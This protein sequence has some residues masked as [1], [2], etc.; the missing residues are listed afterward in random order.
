MET[1]VASTMT[2]PEQVEHLE[3][4]VSERLDTVNELWKQHETTL[5]SIA[6]GKSAFAVYASHQS[7][8]DEPSTYL[9]LGLQ[10]VNGVWGI[11]YTHYQEEFDPKHDGWTSIH[12]CPAF[13][14]AHATAG[15]PKLYEAVLESTGK[16]VPLLDA[17]IVLLRDAMKPPVVEG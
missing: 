12:K 14:R 7:A 4:L 17:A 15:I 5:L 2:F 10:R 11:Y 16:F 9:A 13:T 3:A 8:A 1:T 6:Y